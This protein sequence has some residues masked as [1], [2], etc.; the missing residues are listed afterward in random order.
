M[1]PLREIGKQSTWTDIRTCTANTVPIPDIDTIK[2]EKS[3]AVE[4]IDEG[5]ATLTN[6]GMKLAD[7]CEGMPSIVPTQDSEEIDRVLRL[8][9]EGQLTGYSD[10]LTSTSACNKISPCSIASVQDPIKPTAWN[11]DQVID[12][13]SFEWATTEAFERMAISNSTTEDTAA[14]G[15]DWSSLF[16][17]D[18]IAEHGAI[19]NGLERDHT[20]NTGGDPLETAVASYQ[21]RI[22]AMDAYSNY[23]FGQMDVDGASIHV[24][25][26]ADTRDDDEIAA[27]A[28]AAGDELNCQIEALEVEMKKFL[29]GNECPW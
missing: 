27:S 6:T 8:G 18:F 1:L 20:Q 14:A 2:A 13:N 11:N 4:V 3:H 25:F 19:S 24:N 23:L 9:P 22:E 15:P 12:P 16:G 17:L 5:T 29:T 10:Q 26:E 21:E 7:D 28:I